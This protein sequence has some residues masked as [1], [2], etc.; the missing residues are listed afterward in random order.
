MIRLTERPYQ[1]VLE[2]WTRKALRSTNLK[3][4]E[5]VEAL[6]TV[7]TVIGLISFSWVVAEYTC[8]P[9]KEKE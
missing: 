8:K 9:L 6:E 2:P 3:G 4:G 7:F 1:K 5:K